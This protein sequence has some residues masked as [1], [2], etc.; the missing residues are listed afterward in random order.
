MLNIII[1]SLK[2]RCIVDDFT[3]GSFIIKFKVN[4]VRGDLF[5]LGN[6]T[7]LCLNRDEGRDHVEASKTVKCWKN[8]FLIILKKKMG[9]IEELVIGEDKKENTEAL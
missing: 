6:I 7:K 5:K 4:F 8:D 2:E 1:N 3:V 9:R